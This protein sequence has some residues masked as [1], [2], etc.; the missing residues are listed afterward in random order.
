MDF[1]TA[2]KPWTVAKI[3]ET[4]GCPERTV[5]SWRMGD[6]IPPEWVQ[7]LVVERMKKVK[8]DASGDR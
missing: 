8:P 5:Y 2:L 3:V 6:R 4:L 7:R 1:V